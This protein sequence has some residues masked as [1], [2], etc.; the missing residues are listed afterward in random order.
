[1]ILLSL[2]AVSTKKLIDENGEAQ[3]PAVFS[4][5]VF[6]ISLQ[7]LLAPEKSGKPPTV[8]NL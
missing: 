3:P 8:F 7:S 2:L 1:M 5:H 6:N 4:S